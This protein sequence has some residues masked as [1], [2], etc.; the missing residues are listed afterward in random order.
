MQE[1]ASKS[2]MLNK[3][4]IIEWFPE[5]LNELARANKSWLNI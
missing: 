5:L 4:S 1:K 3:Y 2:D